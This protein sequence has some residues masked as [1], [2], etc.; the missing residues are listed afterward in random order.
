MDRTKITRRVSSCFKDYPQNNS[1]KADYKPLDEAL[2]I[3]KAEY[4][5]LKGW[6]KNVKITVDKEDDFEF[7]WTLDGNNQINPNVI[8][9]YLN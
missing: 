4:N 5:K 2:A 8:V 9:Y 6:G 7:E 3:I 1:I